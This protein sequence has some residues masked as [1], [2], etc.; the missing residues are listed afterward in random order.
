MAKSETERYRHLTQKYCEGVGVDIASHG[1]PVVNWA[2]NFELPVFEYL[3]YNGGNHPVGPVQLRG[4]AQQLPFDTDS[5]DFVYCSHLLEDFADW[6]P[7]LTEWVR[8]LKP[9]GRLIVLIP[10][11]QAWAAAIA[12]GQPPNC[13]HRHEGSEG[14]LSTYAARLGLRVLEDRMT[15][16]FEG[17]YTI[18]FVAVKL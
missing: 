3:T 14:E 12:K 9:G 15:R 10:E 1:D 2:I 7:L 17:D 13:A 6:M 16:C 11:K 5:M 18:L 8:V 4:Y